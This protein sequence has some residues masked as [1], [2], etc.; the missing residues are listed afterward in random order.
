MGA[1]LPELVWVR[2]FVI[3]ATIG[4]RKNQR[5]KPGFSR[6]DEYFDDSLG[7]FSDL[8]L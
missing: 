4:I 2:G 5:A 3:P 7:F 1:I 8:W 6:G